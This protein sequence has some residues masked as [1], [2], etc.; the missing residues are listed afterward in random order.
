V[1]QK[2]YEAARALLMSSGLGLG[3][4]EAEA[5]LWAAILIATGNKERSLAVVKKAV[6]WRPWNQ[7][8]RKVLDIAQGLVHQESQPEFIDEVE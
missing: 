4:E 7:R 2:S 8:L 5:G 1:Q 6:M 3:A